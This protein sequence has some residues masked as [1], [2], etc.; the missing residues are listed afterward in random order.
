MTPSGRTSAAAMTELARRIAA[1]FP[2]SGH[3]V[4]RDPRLK[5]ARADLAA[6]GLTDADIPPTACR[7]TPVLKRVIAGS[8]AIYN[9]PSAQ[10]AAADEALFGERVLVL[11]ERGGW[12]FGQLVDDGY[13]GYLDARALA[14]IPDRPSHRVAH[15][16]THLLSGPSLQA[17][18]LAL[19]PFGALVTV[20][21]ESDDGAYLRIAERDG[22][23]A[24]RHLVTLDAPA[25][26]PLEIAR[27]FLDA[28]YRW[29]GRTAAGIDC[30]GL[31]Q[32][33][34]R[35]TPAGL[36][37]DSDL[38]RLAMEQALGEPVARE[39][40]AAGDLAF[41][42]GHVGIMAD[43]EHVLHANATHM[44]VTIDPLDDVLGWLAAKGHARP[45][46]G[47]FRPRATG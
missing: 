40:A 45:L 26:P 8:V 36:P 34:F 23:V 5:L 31:I 32:L 10:G 27:R 37:R 4:R 44:M 1:W 2:D 22:W 30:S 46:A 47:I 42:P 18:M 20:V 33:A 41:F 12:A 17:A 43:A 29:G 16:F 28:P 14:A 11:E 19:L 35:F 13:V 6:A 25:P 21:E 39:E 15:L 24:A 3:P 38:Q 7:R 9:E